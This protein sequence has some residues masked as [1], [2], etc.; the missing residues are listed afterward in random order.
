MTPIINAANLGPRSAAWLSEIGLSSL[1]DLRELGSIEVMLR[2]KHA[3]I[4]VSL[5]L[6]YALE[7]AL[8][9]RHWQDVKRER[10][11]ELV[12]MWDAAL[13]LDTRHTP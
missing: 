3:G 5:N 2:L 12:L 6:L 1:E 8:E 13:S 4:P 10:K 9:G 7:G 11:G